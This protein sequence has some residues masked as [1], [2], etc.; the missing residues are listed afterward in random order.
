MRHLL[1]TGVGDD[2]LD[3]TDGWQGNIQYLYIEQTDAADNGIEADNR[4]NDVDL[5]P[6]SMPTIGNMSVYGNPRERAFRFRRGTGIKLYNTYVT[7]S[8]RCLNIDSASQRLLGEEIQ[9]G[10]ISFGCTTTIEDGSD[11]NGD[12]Q[13]FLDS[14]PEISENGG[15]VNAVTVDNSFFEPVDFIARLASLV[16]KPRINLTRYHGVLAPARPGQTTAG[17]VSSR[18]PGAGKASSP[19][20]TQKS[21]HPPGAMPQ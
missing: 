4:E 13:A 16:P 5:E 1:V 10:G 2:S 12:V 6:R 18:Q 19:S 3:W 8:D 15:A 14:S 11:P 21:A 7:E 9:F 17:A 20:P